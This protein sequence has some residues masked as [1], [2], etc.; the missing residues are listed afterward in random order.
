M[1]YDRGDSFPFDFES[2]GFPFGSKSKGKLSPRSYPIQCERKWKCSFLSVYFPAG[3]L[4]IL[5]L[6]SSLPSLAIL[7]HRTFQSLDSLGTMGPW[8]AV[9]C[10]HDNRGVLG[11]Q[12]TS[13]L[14]LS[15]QPWTQRYQF[16][17]GISRHEFHSRSKCNG[18]HTLSISCTR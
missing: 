5:G 7:C 8:M 10:C 12:L 18:A 4:C 15:L 6:I 13:R 11:A 1:G 9:S 2:N 14:S 16:V 3:L 17:S